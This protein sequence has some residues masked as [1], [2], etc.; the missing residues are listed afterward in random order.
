MK[1][2]NIKKILSPGFG[3]NLDHDVSL[4]LQRSF[5]VDEDVAELR[6]GNLEV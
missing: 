4:M 3:E 2:S 1:L 6:R 5:S